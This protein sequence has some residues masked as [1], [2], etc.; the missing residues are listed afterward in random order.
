MTGA[1]PPAAL[2]LLA[3]P[4][5]GLAALLAGVAASLCAQAQ[6]PLVPPQA[7]LAR[8]LFDEL[9]H[10]GLDAPHSYRVTD[11]YLRRD[12]VRLHLQHGTLVFLQPVRGRITGAV[13]EGAA[14]ALVLPPDRAERHQLLKFSGSPILTESFTNAYLRFT[15]DTF[16]ELLAQIRSGQGRPYHAPELIERWQ[17]LLLSLNHAHTSRTLLDLLQSPPIPYFYAGIS[18]QHLGAFDIIVDNRRPEQILVGQLRWEN[19]Q[20]YYDVWCSFARRDSRPPAAPGRISAYRLEATVTPERELEVQADLDLEVDRREQQVLVFSLSRFLQVEQVEEVSELAGPANRGPPRPLEFLQNVTLTAEEARYRGTDV[21]LVVLPP[22]PANVTPASAYRRP[23]RL[24]YRGQII[25]DVGAGVLHVGARDTW[26]P[27]LDPPTLARFEMRFRLPS[28]LE[29]VAVGSLRSQREE[30]GWKESVWETE[31]PLPVAG[32]NVGSYEVFTEERE[33]AQVSVYANRQLEP[34][35]AR[36]MRPERV[37][38]PQ[39]PNFKPEGLSLDLLREAEP[40]RPAFRLEQVGNTVAGALRYFTGLFGPVP[41]TPLKVSQVPGRIAQGYPGLIYLSTFS[42]LPEDQQMRLGLSEMAREHFSEVTPPH[43]TAHQWWGNWVWMPDYRQQ[44]LAEALSSYSALLYLEQ[45]PGGEGSL[46]KWLE[47][48]RTTLLETDENGR[49]TESTGALSLG[50]RLTSSQSP[51]GYTSVVYSKGPW[52][53]HMLRELLRDP[54]SGSDDIFLGV[55]RELAAEG[56]AQPLTTDDFQKRFEVVLPAY[57]DLEESGRLDWFF[58]QWVHDAGIPRYHLEWEAEGDERRGWEVEGT[59]E[60]EDV[61]DLFTMPVP[62]YVKHGEELTRL[63]RVV[64]T[65]PVTAFH[66]HVTAPP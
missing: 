65:G 15:D 30:G 63:G 55:L 5:A 41:Y 18:G 1:R 16:A 54:E 40:A 23:L 38:P 32:F 39:P 47:R 48:Y 53:I 8:A 56:G 9:D 33:A 25:T 29:L 64:V 35:L 17:P 50:A 3:P 42:F 52:V 36:A 19:E 46:R 21:A 7:G 11:L 12:A 26:Y 22:V 44:W 43:E 66:F 51:T 4:R 60:Q 24:R 10:V 57:A 58:Q 34:E 31:A 61:S 2:R 37:P 49:E 20:R 59:I 14:E 27:A 62:V 45:Q 6:P 28:S 13:F